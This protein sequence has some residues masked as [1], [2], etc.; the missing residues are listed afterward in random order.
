M[1]TSH[2][3]Y[4]FWVIGSSFVGKLRKNPLTSF[5]IPYIILV[6]ISLRRVAMVG[7]C[8][9]EI[10]VYSN[11]EEA[12]AYWKKNDKVI[13]VK[14]PLWRANKIHFKLLKQGYG[15]WEASENKTLIIHY[16]KLSE[17]RLI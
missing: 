13:K 15:Y 12:I 17:R 16:F 9:N 6:E 3:L 14:M 4:F 5:H 10:T 2:S 8:A 11:F 1:L 7:T